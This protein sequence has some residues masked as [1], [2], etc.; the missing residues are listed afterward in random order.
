MNWLY[1]IDWSA[2]IASFSALVAAGALLWNIWWSNKI[3]KRDALAKI[4]G[5]RVA[6]I[7]NMRRLMVEFDAA[8]FRYDFSQGED[9]ESLYQINKLNQEIIISFNPDEKE[10]LQFFN[11]LNE[12]LMAANSRDE[13][14]RVRDADKD[15][16][17]EASS[18]FRDEGRRMLKREWEKAKL[19]LR[20]VG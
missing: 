19:E 18:N 15:P 10:N 6:W 4:A 11:T 13:S 12:L 5:H 16:V 9:L 20:G 1:P 3:L 2:T 14:T 17:I 7:E 8:V